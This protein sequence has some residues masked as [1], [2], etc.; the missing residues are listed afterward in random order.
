MGIA[1]C[2]TYN[3]VLNEIYKLRHK[4]DYF[5]AKIELLR[6][7]M[8]QSPKWL[9]WLF[10]ADLEDYNGCYSKILYRYKTLQNLKNNFYKFVTGITRSDYKK[11][12]KLVDLLD[13]LKLA[14]TVDELV[15][16]FNGMDI[17]LKDLKVRINKINVD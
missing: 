8:C 7:T 16:N 5:K 9:R 4:L 13:K 17:A 12:D 3:D 2:I 11:T 6:I 14:E 10:K 1:K 15:V